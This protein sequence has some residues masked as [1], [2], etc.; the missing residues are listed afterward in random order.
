MT[1]MNEMLILEPHFLAAYLASE[2]ACEILD[3]LPDTDLIEELRNLIY[4]QYELLNHIIEGKHYGTDNLVNFIEHTKNIN[5]DMAT[6]KDN[7]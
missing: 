4:I 7:Q 1:T 5:E 2:S 6:I 3:V